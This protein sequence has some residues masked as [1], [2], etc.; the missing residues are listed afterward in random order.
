MVRDNCSFW[1]PL[2]EVSKSSSP[3]FVLG[4]NKWNKQFLPTKFFGHSYE[5]KDGEFEHIP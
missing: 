1:I 4:S 5:Q 2:D 3:E